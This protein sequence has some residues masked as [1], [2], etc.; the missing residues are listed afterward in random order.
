[1]VSESFG[2]GIRGG[3]EGRGGVLMWD[4]LKLSHLTYTS[5]TL[6]LYF[7]TRGGGGGVTGTDHVCIAVCFFSVGFPK[8]AR[9]LTPLAVDINMCVLSG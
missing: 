7:D 9:V 4:R 6:Y 8:H 3:G 5:Y 1:M 2:K